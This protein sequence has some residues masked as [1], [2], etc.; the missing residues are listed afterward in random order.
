MAPNSKHGDDYTM[1]QKERHFFDLFDL[2][3]ERGAS[4]VDFY[5]Q[6]RNLVTASLKKQ[7]DIILWQNSKVLEAD[8][9]L[10]PTFEDL[11]FANVLFLID[12]NLLGRVKEDYC[13]FIGR[14]KK[15]LMDYR[16]DILNH[17]PTFI[18]KIEDILPEKYCH[19]LDP[20]ER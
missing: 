14:S 5:N 16:T 17:V 7:G 20:F 6:Y 1:H 9:E 2:Q 8:E 13:H 18:T 11:I 10:S 19:D 4:A 15:S 3:Y 12:S